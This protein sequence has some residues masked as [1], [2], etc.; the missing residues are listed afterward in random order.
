MSV[1]L[2]NEVISEFQDR[3]I[4]F[5]QQ[6]ITSCIYIRCTLKR[7]IEKKIMKYS[8]QDKIGYH[9][10]VNFVGRIRATNI[11]LIVLVFRRKLQILCQ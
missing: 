8:I 1:T 4:I 6:Y 9:M 10:I 3:L 11:T 5:L 2:Y 7:H